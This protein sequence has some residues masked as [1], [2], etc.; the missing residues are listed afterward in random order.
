MLKYDKSKMKKKKINQIVVIKYFIIKRDFQS[1]QDYL[2]KSTRNIG[3][4]PA[5]TKIFVA[6]HV[7][8]VRDRGIGILHIAEIRDPFTC[9]ENTCTALEVFAPRF[10]FLAL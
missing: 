10:F 4:L 6:L 5:E 2:V 3:G 8:A 9:T 1:T 7:T